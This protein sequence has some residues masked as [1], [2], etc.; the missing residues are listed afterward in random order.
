MHVWVHFLLLFSPQ[1]WWLRLGAA[2]VPGVI[3]IWATYQ[4]GKKLF[5][6]W[7]GSLAALLL[8]TSSFHIF[9][10]QELR[11]YA[12]PAMWAILSWL[13]IVNGFKKTEWKPWLFFIGFSIAGWY[14]SYLYPFLFCAQI[15]FLFFRF[16]THRREICLS[17]LAIGGAFLAWLPM[18]LAQLQ[19]GQTLRTDL[20]GWEKVVSFDQIK[21]LALTGGK[22][23]FG[24]TDLEAS[25]LFIVSVTG[26]G[27]LCL[28]LLWGFFQN[29]FSERK[30]M[31]KVCCSS[32]PTKEGPFLFTRFL[33][34][35]CIFCFASFTTSFFFTKYQ[36]KNNSSLKSN[37][38]G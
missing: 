5:S 11:P 35:T 18:F 4:I 28:I 20:P 29:F 16:P 17:L 22:F 12:L 37:I 32:S 25:G 34:F 19:A 21:S 33:P 9:Y 36:T 30:T 1:E 24:V 15:I 13:I 31:V 2:T 3:T 10:S 7:V 14:S 38:C 8:A 27:I 23:L 6:T 26:L